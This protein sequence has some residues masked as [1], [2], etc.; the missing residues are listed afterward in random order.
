MNAYLAAEFDSRFAEYMHDP[1]F[2]GGRSIID[3]SI[4]TY[5]SETASTTAMDEGFK[6]FVI[7]QMK[8]FLFSGHGTTSAVACYVFYMLFGH[9]DVLARLRA[10]HDEILGSDLDSVPAMISSQPHVLNR[11]PYTMAVVKET[12]RL[13]PVASTL[14]QGQP[15]FSVID[16]DGTAYPTDGCLVWPNPHALHRSPDYW[17]RAEAFLPE[18]W[19]VPA[20]H[21]LHPVQ[22]AWRPFEFGPRSCIGQDLALLELRVVVALVARRFDLRVVYDE[23]DRLHPRRGPKTVGGERAYTLISGGPSDGLPCR[24]AVRKSRS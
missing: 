20:G 22:G 12:L 14:R 8:L 5:L 4:Q 17:P 19:L 2:A 10:E 11:L 9:A 3:R 18:R 7:D 21:E 6:T 1:S 16:G 15:G 23:W 24:V 13:Y